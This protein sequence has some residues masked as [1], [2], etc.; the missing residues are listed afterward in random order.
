MPPIDLIQRTGRPAVDDY[1][2]GLI[3]IFEVAFP[4]RVRAYYLAGSFATADA[5]TSSDIDIQVIFK[6]AFTAGEAERVTQLRDSCQ[7]ISAFQLDLP[8]RCEAQYL[9]GA[10]DPLALKTATLLLHGT[11]IRDQLVVPPLERYAQLITEAPRHTLARLRNCPIIRSPLDYPDPAG[12]FYG[13]D[14]GGRTQH[15]V[16]AMGWAATAIIVLD[17]GQYVARKRDWLDMY[18][19]HIAGAWVPFLSTVYERCRNHWDYAIPVDAAGRAALRALCRQ[20]LDFENHYLARYRAYL[21]DQLAGGDP[22]GQALALERLAQ[23]IY[24]DAEVA[25]AIRTLADSPVESLRTAA[26]QAL[27]AAGDEHPFSMV[28]VKHDDLNPAGDQ[29]RVNDPSRRWHPCS[30]PAPDP[31]P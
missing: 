19:Q 10:E 20:A 31:P 29:A 27:A 5:I 25:A 30:S 26:G 2:A 1:L 18:R 14:I 23:V 7:R 24:P 17:A 15:F 12:E 8:V 28:S 6:G 9:S 22:S 11:D 4:D 16:V 13:Y 3:G 21:L